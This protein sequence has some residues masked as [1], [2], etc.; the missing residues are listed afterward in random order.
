MV[1]T[2]SAFLS[3][4]FSVRPDPRSIKPQLTVATP[5]VPKL[6]TS[7][8][9]SPPAILVRGREN[10]TPFSIYKSKHLPQQGPKSEK[11][12]SEDLRP[13]DPL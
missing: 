1:A 5:L 11:L 10:S 12:T 2:D 4:G 7:D 13:C 6:C 9:G 8:V 3:V